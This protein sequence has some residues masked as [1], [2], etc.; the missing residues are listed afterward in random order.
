[1]SF[2]NPSKNNDFLVQHINIMRYSF[3]YFTG[4]QLGSPKLS[5]TE[6]AEELYNAP[7]ALLT[8]TADDDPIFN[9]ANLTAQ[10]LFELSWY[11]ITKLPSRKSA[12]SPNQND[13]NSLLAK[14]AENGFVDNYTGIRITA[15]DKKFIIKKGIIWNLIDKN[16]NYYGQ[17]AKFKF[18]EFL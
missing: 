15:N 18:W 10:K 17:G 6:N 4:K 14:V 8:H 12:E 11:D 5:D 7:F 16:G 13:R 3:E 2:K 9:Y 1:M